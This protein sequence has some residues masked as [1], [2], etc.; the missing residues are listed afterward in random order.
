MSIIVGSFSVCVRVSQR[1]WDK[2]VT[3]RTV[4]S[5]WCPSGGGHL[6]MRPMKAAVLS[7]CK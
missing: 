6:P 1:I 2:M 3:V 4:Y 7:A 5:S